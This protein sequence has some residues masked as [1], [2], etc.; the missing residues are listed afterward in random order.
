MTAQHPQRVFGI[1]PT[2]SLSV[3]TGF[4]QGLAVFKKSLAEVSPGSSDYSILLPKGY[5]IMES[6]DYGFNTVYYFQASDTIK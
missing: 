1:L 2:C 3:L 4:G 5:S 6:N